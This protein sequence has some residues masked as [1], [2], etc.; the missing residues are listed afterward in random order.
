MDT[1]KAIKAAIESYESGATT[2]AEM[3][4]RIFQLTD[5]CISYNED[6]LYNQSVNN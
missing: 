6:H 1:L 4:V 3:I 2:Y 5:N